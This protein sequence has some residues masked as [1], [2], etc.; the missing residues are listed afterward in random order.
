MSITPEEKYIPLADW[1]ALR[2]GALA[3]EYTLRE[4]ARNGEIYPPPQKVGKRWA[5]LPTAQRLTH[6]RPSLVSRL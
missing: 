6:G 4:W 3:S 5:V 2:Y 1:G